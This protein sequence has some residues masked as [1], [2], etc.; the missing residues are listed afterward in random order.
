MF[1]WR[2][3]GVYLQCPQAATCS[4]APG[5][6]LPTAGGV[7]V[8][9]IAGNS[10]RAYPSQPCPTQSTWA[11]GHE[12]WS[13]HLFHQI[14]YKKRARVSGIVKRTT[15]TKTVSK[16]GLVFLPC[17]TQWITT[18]FNGKSTAHPLS[19]KKQGEGIICPSMAQAGWKVQRKRKDWLPG[20]RRNS[21]NHLLNHGMQDKCWELQYKSYYSEWGLRV[22]QLIGKIPFPW[23]P[24]VPQ[25]WVLIFQFWVVYCCRGVQNCSKRVQN[26]A[27]MGKHKKTQSGRP[28]CF[29]NQCSDASPP[30][31]W[32]C[33]PRRVVINGCF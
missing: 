12:K 19:P 24:L 10:S 7:A 18:Y 30:R 21:V 32:N 20:W 25:Q 5:P 29:S 28:R 9:L 8:A 11:F 2:Q 6:D 16:F 15:T 3:A 1:S 23:I 33:H 17:P 4:L 14:N 22:L 26:W 13:S 27:K 31:L